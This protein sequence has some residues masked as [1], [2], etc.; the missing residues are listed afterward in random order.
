MV[1][2]VQTCALPIYPLARSALLRKALMPY[3]LFA[4][5]APKIALIP[6]FVLWF[7]LD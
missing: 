7:G 1:T 5:T 6:L 2:G 4:Q 3:V